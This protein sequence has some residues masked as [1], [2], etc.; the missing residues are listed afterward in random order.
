MLEAQILTQDKF[1][2]IARRHLLERWEISPSGAQ[3]VAALTRKVPMY[4]HSRTSG[5]PRISMIA[6]RI[7]KPSTSRFVPLLE[8]LP[9]PD[10]LHY[11]L[12]ENVLDM[13][14]K[15]NTL[16]LDVQRQFGFVGGSQ[17]ECIKYFHRRDL[18]PRM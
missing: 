8:A 14:G 18:P 12:E 2:A 3:A 15:S 4:G 11:A 13:T 9:T 10:S 6:N 7:E 1:I 5:T 17:A 16:F